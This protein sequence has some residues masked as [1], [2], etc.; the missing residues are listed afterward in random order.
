MGCAA[1]ALL[2]LASTSLAE[3]PGHAFIGATFSQEFDELGVLTAEVTG[4][5]PPTAPAAG[6][7][8]ADIETKGLYKVLYQDGDHAHLYYEEL[9]KHGAKMAGESAG[10]EL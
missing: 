9:L 6:A 5:T 4:Y 1:G 7:S 10:G 2:F 3:E 8:V